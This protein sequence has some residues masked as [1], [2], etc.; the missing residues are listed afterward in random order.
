MA[1]Q[2]SGPNHLDERMEAQGFRSCGISRKLQYVYLLAS[3]GRSPPCLH[4]PFFPSSQQPLKPRLTLSPSLLTRNPVRQP[5]GT[6]LR[7]LRRGHPRRGPAQ[8]ETLHQLRKPSA[9]SR[10]RKTRFPQCHG[11][12]QPKRKR[13]RG[14]QLCCSGRFVWA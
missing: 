7:L 14:I 12:L 9:T 2:K 11:C 13:D 5:G 8:L 4:S 10:P 1:A 3:L 6:L